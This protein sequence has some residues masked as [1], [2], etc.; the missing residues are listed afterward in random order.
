MQALD[1]IEEKTMGI[2]EVSNKAPHVMLIRTV[3]IVCGESQLSSLLKDT[4][5]HTK[6]VESSVSCD[7]KNPV[8]SNPGNR[9]A[10]IFWDLRQ[11]W[12]R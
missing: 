3:T 2:K 12:K 10:L 8:G 1:C 9:L 7:L 4:Q 11:F 5:D 6:V